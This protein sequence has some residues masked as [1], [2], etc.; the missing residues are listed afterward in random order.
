MEAMTVLRI[1]HSKIRIVSDLDPWQTLLF[2]T[3]A[4]FCLF[5]DSPIWKKRE[6]KT[7]EKKREREK[8]KS[9]D[10]LTFRSPRGY[11]PVV[12]AWRQGCDMTK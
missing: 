5:P 3:F 4:V 2:F 10:V 7:K 9:Y 6:K 8:R 1:A 11:Y 12:A